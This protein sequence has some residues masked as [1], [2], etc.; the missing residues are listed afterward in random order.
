MENKKARKMFEK[1][2]YSYEKNDL[3]S[4]RYFKKFKNLCKVIAFDFYHSEV[5][6]FYILKGGKRNPLELSFSEIEA[7]NKQLKEYEKS[8]NFN[9]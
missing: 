1:L 3:G 8:E 2:G 7:I 6:P 5:N 4:I 9:E